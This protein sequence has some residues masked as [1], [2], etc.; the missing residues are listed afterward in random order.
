MGISSFIF[1]CMY[2]TNLLIFI[3]GFDLIPVYNTSTA[4]FTLF[5]LYCKFHL[6]NDISKQTFLKFSETPAIAQT[7]LIN[8]TLHFANSTFR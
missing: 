3:L 8:K 5:V 1:F 6:E 4:F 7:N 2:S